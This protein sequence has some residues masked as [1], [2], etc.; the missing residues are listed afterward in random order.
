MPSRFH[1]R[2]QGDLG[3]ACAIEWLTSVGAV[4]SFPLFHSPDYD[5]IADF[6]QH[7]MRVQVK[8]SRRVAPSTGNFAVQLATSGG[9]Q[10]WTGVV[11][12]FDASRVDFLFVLVSDGRRWFIPASEVEGRRAITV[13][14]SKY[15]EFEMGL[16][17]PLDQADA[18]GSKL[19][20]REGGRRSWRAGPDCKSG[21]SLLSGFDSHPPHSPQPGVCTCELHQGVGRTRLSANHQL[22]I[23]LAVFE[24]A[25][26]QVGDRFRVQ[27]AGKGRVVL[28]RIQEYLED[29]AQQPARLRDG[30]E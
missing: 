10:S 12:K 15:S 4:V 1:P 28:T 27:A 3:E 5:L 7:P 22:T 21:A 8:T 26:L 23:P 25:G 24:A 9:N 19:V 20:R 17:A 29:H 2:T 14:G 30:E 18:T 11:R 16:T 6:G 13:G